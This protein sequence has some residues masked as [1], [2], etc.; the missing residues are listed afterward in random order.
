MPVE[1]SER[2]GRSFSDPDL[3]GIPGF[4]A[5]FQ[6][7]PKLALNF[8]QQECAHMQSG[9]PIEIVKVERLGD[10][11]IVEFDDGRSY[12]YSRDLLLCMIAYAQE[13]EDLGP[14]ESWATHL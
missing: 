12:I 6:Q 1:R 2:L 9:L 11:I 5:V 4:I 10:G 13:V 7:V 8:L 3:C 14:D